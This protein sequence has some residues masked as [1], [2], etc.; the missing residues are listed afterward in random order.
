MAVKTIT[1]DLEAYEALRRHKGNGQSF[2]T[3][4]KEHFGGRKTGRALLRAVA[5]AKLAD[6]TIE[7]IEKVAEARQADSARQLDL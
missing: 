6:S 1:I 2:S 3:V 5:D 7:A 4:I